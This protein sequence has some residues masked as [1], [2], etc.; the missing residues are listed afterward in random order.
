MPSHNYTTFYYSLYSY[1]CIFEVKLEL[2]PPVK[3]KRCAKGHI[4]DIRFEAFV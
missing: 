4:S 1:Y 2:Y 3:D